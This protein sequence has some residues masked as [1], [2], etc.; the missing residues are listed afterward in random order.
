MVIQASCWEVGDYG[1]DV[2]LLCP[3][4][5]PARN[6]PVVPQARV[7]VDRTEWVVTDILQ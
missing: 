6:M 1:C 7:K 5:I 4:P 3:M 2:M